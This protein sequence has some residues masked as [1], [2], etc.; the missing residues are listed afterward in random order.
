[1][2]LCII[3]DN[4]II[5]E[6]SDA[7]IRKDAESEDRVPLQNA[8]SRHEQNHLSNRNHRRKK[9]RRS[10]LIR[11]SRAVHSAGKFLQ[12]S[13]HCLLVCRPVFGTFPRGRTI[14]IKIKVAI[15]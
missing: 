5:C 9:G 8:A 7:E 3:L 2:I 11:V 15:E 13:E 12:K 6:F 4:H 10:G 1:M 14:V